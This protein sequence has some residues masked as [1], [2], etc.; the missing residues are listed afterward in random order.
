[1]AEVEAIA[2]ERGCFRLEVT[3]QRHRQEAADF[4]LVFGF[5][6]RDCGCP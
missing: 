4:C 5:L 6:E 3:T 1:M 2:R